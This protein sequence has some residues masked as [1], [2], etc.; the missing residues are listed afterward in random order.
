MGDLHCALFPKVAPIGTA[1]FI[2]LAKGT[3]D[4]TN[5]KTGQKMHGSAAL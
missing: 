3:K 1:N 2:G 4:W 5:P